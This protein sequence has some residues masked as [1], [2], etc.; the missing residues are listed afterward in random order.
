MS[1]KR[2]IPTFSLD[3]YQQYLT[4]TPI[5]PFIDERGRPHKRKP[6]REVIK[7]MQKR[8]AA[9]KAENKL[10]EMVR[11]KLWIERNQPQV[12]LCLACGVPVAYRDFPIPHWCD[13][14][15]LNPDLCHKILAD[16]H[17]VT[18]WAEV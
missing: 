17:Q 11:R 16:D 14:S 2:I 6:S 15:Y 4:G 8:N 9:R 13:W 18:L 1:T 7:L 10:Y 3:E 12:K 5:A